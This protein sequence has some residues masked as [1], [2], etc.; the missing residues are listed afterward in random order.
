M[1]TQRKEDLLPINFE[2]NGNDTLG[3]FEL[4]QFSPR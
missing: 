1:I 3:G 4:E 2:S